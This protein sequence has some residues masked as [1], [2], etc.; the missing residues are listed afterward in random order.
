MNKQT[1]PKMRKLRASAAIASASFIAASALAQDGFVTNTKPYTVPVGS[2]YEI[3]PILSVADKVP[4]TSDPSKQYQMVGIPD[5]L[6]AYPNSDGT[7]SVLMNHEFTKSTTSQPIIGGPLQRGAFISR[8][9][10][11]EDGSVLSGERAY[12]R[13]FDE[14]TG[15]SF[16][17]ADSTNGSPAFSRFCSASVADPDGGYDRPIYLAGEE[18]SGADTFDGRGGVLTATFDNELHTLKKFP[19]MPWENA[20]PRPFGGNEV[21]VMCMEDGPSTPDSQLYMY[22]GK[23]ERRAGASVLSRNGL[24]N[25]KLYAF[26]SKDPSRNSESTFLNGSI[27]GEWVEIR[28]VENLTDTQLE[29]ASDAAGA[30]GFIRTEDGAWS[31][32]SRKDYYFVTTGGNVGNRLGRGYHLEL[33]PGNPLKDARLTVIYNADQ[34]IA[35]GG[36]TALSPDNIDTNGDYLMVQEDGTADTRPVMAQKGRDGSI[37]RFDLN[38]NFAAERVAQLNPPGRDGVPVGPGVWET[39]GIIDASSM[40]G[41][42]S[43]I[44]DVQAHRPTNQPAPGT[45]EDGQLLIMLPAGQ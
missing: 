2:A 34:I 27:T 1:Q 37:W 45:V 21:V 41:D 19:R 14:R 8:F 12:D 36:D 9:V 16:P 28:D 31:K 15:A 25:G 3:K 32:N 18:S 10:L 26:R 23:K 39:S 29:A 42:N 11:A 17:P 24:D 6:G 30:F 20:L 22:V 5:G 44:F 43:W 35:A 7:V 33:N 40:F 38:N 13:V 4:E